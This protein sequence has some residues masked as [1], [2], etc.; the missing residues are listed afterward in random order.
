[1]TKINTNAL[2]NDDGKEVDKNSSIEKES[3]NDSYLT[4]PFFVCYEPRTSMD[5]PEPSMNKPEPS[6]NKPKPPTLLSK[7]MKSVKNL[8]D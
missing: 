2:L 6:M 8:I 5:K 1:M 3:E 4:I 7:L